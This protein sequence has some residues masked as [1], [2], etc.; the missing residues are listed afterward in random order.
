M[1]DP[2]PRP[3]RTNILGV[4]VSAINMQQALDQIACWIERR[5][6]TYVVVCPV[7]TVM[8]P[9]SPRCGA[10]STVRGWSHRTAC[11]LSFSAVAWGSHTS[12]RVQA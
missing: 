12:A 2:C 6:R 10:S 11:R 7:Y 1:D 4:G 9:G 5:E 8:M 3:E